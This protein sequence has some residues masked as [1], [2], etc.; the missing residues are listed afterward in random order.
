VLRDRGTLWGSGSIDREQGISKAGNRRLRHIMT[1][2]AWLWVRHQPGSALTRWFRERAD[3]ERGRV[4]RISTVALA[5]KLLIALWR[6]VMQGELP[7]GA[8]VDHPVTTPNTWISATDA[9]PRRIPSGG[10]HNVLAAPPKFGTARR[11]RRPRDEELSYSR[12]ERR[13][14]VRFRGMGAA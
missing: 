14:D 3:E 7:E 10:P 5:R 9:N 13:P 4:R 12:D 1:E 2:L 8:G 11:S 6:Y